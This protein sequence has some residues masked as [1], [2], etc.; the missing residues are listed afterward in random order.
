[1]PS[2]ILYASPLLLPVFSR[3]VLSGVRP[4]PRSLDPIGVQLPISHNALERISSV[5]PQPDGRQA[6]RAA[7]G[8]RVQPSQAWHQM[9]TV[10]GTTLFVEFGW[11]AE[12]STVADRDRITERSHEASGS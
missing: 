3:W 4:I 12:L 7:R 9:C 6:R 8:V 10:A 1:M 5:L 2:F 11:D